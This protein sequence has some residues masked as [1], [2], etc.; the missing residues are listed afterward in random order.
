MG[1]EEAFL[2][3]LYLPPFLPPTPNLKS[4]SS[5]CLP[6]TCLLA[7]S[8]QRS[9]PGLRESTRISRG[10]PGGPQRSWSRGLEAR[11]LIPE[12]EGQST[13]LGLQYT[14][15]PGSRRGRERGPG[16]LPGLFFLLRVAASPPPRQAAG[17]DPGETPRSGCA[18]TV[19]GGG[20][21]VRG[22]LSPC[23]KIP[24]APGPRSSSGY[25]GGARTLPTQVSVIP[26]GGRSPELL[27]PPVPPFI[28]QTE[29]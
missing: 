12:H 16:C 2:L 5:P 19:P 1:H 11:R 25:L 23:Y 3:S 28:P 4:R 27:L 20:G 13:S 7:L 10:A 9:L 22:R 18:R 6:S 15:S 24:L 29:K 21:W 14:T 8:V 26:A 17:G